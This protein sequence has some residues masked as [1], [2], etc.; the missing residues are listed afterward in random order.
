[1]TD[2]LRTFLLILALLPLYALPAA[3]ATKDQAAAVVTQA[4][5]GFIR[6]AYRAFRDRSLALVADTDKLCQSPN[7][8]TLTGARDSFR[9]AVGTWAQAEVIRFGPITEDNRLDRVLF[10]PDRRGIGLRQIQA[11]LAAR[12]P[13]LTDAAK[14]AE[15]SVAIQGFGALEFVLFGTD[16]D[17]L[18]T[19]GGAFRCAY[20]RAIAG[21]LAAIATAVDRAWSDREGFAARWAAPGPDNPSYRTPDE[22]LGELVGVFVDGLEWLRDVRLSGFIGE[23]PDKDNPKQALFWRSGATLAVIEAN[24][25]GLSSLLEAS[26]LETVLPADAG[27]IEDSMRFEF[28]NAVRVATEL[29]GRPVAD[30]LA[31]AKLRSRLSYLRIVTSS[32]SEIFGTR[33][34][35]ALSL[36]TGFSSLDGD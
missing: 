11:A 30:I 15:K 24:L 33:L 34:S 16:S 19:A 23:T 7:G 10:F 17:A 18:A 13:G 3:A 26:N 36:S 22:A 32:L 9:R 6:P 20:G 1:L 8:D 29:E 12:D 35:P 14:L 5:D 25:S 28:G 4:V 31:D 21:N 27:W 2:A